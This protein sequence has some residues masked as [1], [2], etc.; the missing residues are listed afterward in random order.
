MFIDQVASPNVRW[1][2][3]PRRAWNKQLLKTFRQCFHDNRWSHVNLTKTKDRDLNWLHRQNS[4][5]SFAL[6]AF[7]MSTMPLRQN[8]KEEAANLPDFEFLSSIRNLEEVLRNM[9]VFFPPQMGFRESLLYTGRDNSRAR[10]ESAWLSIAFHSSSQTMTIFSE[11][12]WGFSSV[13]DNNSKIIWRIL[14]LKRASTCLSRHV[15]VRSRNTV[16]WKNE[17]IVFEDDFARE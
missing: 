8:R 17:E 9:I 12:L 13:R 11:V 2:F 16:R 4:K 1:R 3:P 15:G 10:F 14:R 7:Y 6:L 5:L